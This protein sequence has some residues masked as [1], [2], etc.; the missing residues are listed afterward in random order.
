MSC[1]FFVTFFIID[2][3]DI[4]LF[5]A[6]VWISMWGFLYRY[7]LRH[8]VNKHLSKRKNDSDNTCYSTELHV[9]YMRK[10]AI[11]LNNSRFMDKIN[12]TLK[13]E[14]CCFISL[15][16]VPVVMHKCKASTMFKFINSEDDNDVDLKKVGDRIKKQIKS[17]HCKMTI[18]FTPKKIEATL[19]RCS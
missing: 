12:K 2:T 8:P 6:A 19:H 5:Q 11:Y 15:S 16:L 17:Q 13:H 10:G 3:S 14:V 7:S 9:V 1:V 4:I 18:Q